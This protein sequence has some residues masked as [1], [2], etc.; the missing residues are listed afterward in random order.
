MIWEKPGV[1]YS[2]I[3]NNGKHLNTV[4]KFA[5]C[6]SQS[7]KSK[8]SRWTFQYGRRTNKNQQQQ[9][10]NPWE[11]W[12]LQKEK[13]SRITGPWKVPYLIFTSFSLKS[14][15]NQQ[16]WLAKYDISSSKFMF[17]RTYVLTCTSFRNWSWASSWSGFLCLNLRSKFSHQRSHG[18]RH[19]DCL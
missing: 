19:T 8:L 7:L 5:F 15:V 3:T 18:H 17:G 4:G 2:S 9:Q 13:E 11:N 12:V 1:V 6:V 10:K 16:W 14:I